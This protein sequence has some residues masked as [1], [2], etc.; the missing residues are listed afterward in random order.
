MRNPNGYGAIIKLNGKRRRPW[1]IVMTTGW[2]SDGK[3]QRTYLGY[4]RTR[5]EAVKA[6]A[7]YN[8]NP[9]DLNG[10]TFA[11][12]F[13][14]W[15]SEKFPK[16]SRSNINSYNAAFAK[17]SVIHNIPIQKITF[18][19]LQ[20]CVTPC[21]PPTQKKVRTLLSQMYEYAMKRGL[22]TRDLSDLI[23]VDPIKKS[24]LHHRF[25]NA[26][27]ETL[28]KASDDEYIQVILMMIYSGVRPGELLNLLSS[29]VDIEGNTFYIRAG[30]N[31][32]AI[33]RVP[34]HYRTLPFFEAWKNKKRE[35]L[36]TDTRGIM[37][38]FQRNHGGYTEAYFTDK[39]RDLGILT[40]D[41]NSEKRIHKPDD[42]RHT[43][44]T[45][46]SEK[47]L[48]EIYRRII[49]GHSGKGVGEQ[50]YTHI[51]FEEL[52]AELNKL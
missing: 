42:T 47:K 14:K 45:L 7:D 19:E 28:W 23:E 6:L 35:Y 34:I 4:Y 39:L 26:E 10:Y 3:Q 32:N 51:S 24:S 36:I 52:L 11:E 44:T 33:R 1:A 17:C 18:S 9:Y 16:I 30:K 38:N 13:A 5:L 15:S 21:T 43:F 27:I 25:T 12:V 40:Y 8:D 29:D 50:T 20:A 48:S 46:W 49:Q 41:L 2:T 31:E 37:F 22:V